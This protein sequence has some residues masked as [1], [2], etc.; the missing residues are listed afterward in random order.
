MSKPQPNFHGQRAFISKPE[1]IAF[2]D[3]T[4]GK[5]HFLVITLTNASISFNSF[6][7]L[8]LPENIRVS[9]Y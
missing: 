9:P 5:V 3:F 7:V 2:K 8:P 4:V 1:T 6:N